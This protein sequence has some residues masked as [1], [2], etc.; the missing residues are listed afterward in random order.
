[1]LNGAR[2]SVRTSELVGDE[3]RATALSGA[4]VRIPLQAVAAINVYHGRAI[5]LSDL[6][7]KAY[8]HTPYLGVSWPVAVDHCVSGGDLRL[9]GGTYDKGLGLHSRSRVTYTLS[10]GRPPVRDDRWLG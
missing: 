3:L 4:V 8:E 1:M 7:P 10:C 2:L 5:Y 6:K 9:G